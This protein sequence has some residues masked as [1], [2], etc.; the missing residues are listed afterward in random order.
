MMLAL[1]LVGCG[2]FVSAD[3]ALTTAGSTPA[4]VDLATRDALADATHLGH[5]ALDGLM[6]AHAVDASW[7]GG[8]ARAVT[9]DEILDGPEARVALTDALANLASVD[10][11]AL[12]SHDEQLAFWLNLYNA[13]TVQAVV[14]A[15]SADPTYASVRADDWALF[16]VAFAQVDGEALSLNQIE[17]GVMRADPASLDLYFA[18]QDALRAKAEAWHAALWGGGPVDARIHVGLNC[19]SVGCP[20]LLDGAYQ[21]ATLQA[22]LDAQATRFVDHP[23]KG[24]GPDGISQLFGWF[25]ADF[26]GSHGGVR[27]FVRQYRGGGDEGVDYDT[28]LPYDWALNA[29]D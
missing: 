25:R 28:S 8:A 22:T 26:E 3:A 14:D 29:A 12:E 15:R 20:D 1:S 24:A 4:R 9:Y 5:Y 17:H 21:A 11:M 10:P 19:A 2:Q 18:D 27:A 6:R 23:G 7:G 13:W 16:N